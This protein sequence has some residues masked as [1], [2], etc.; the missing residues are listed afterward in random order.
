MRFSYLAI[1]YVIKA[2]V[3]CT[4]VK[5]YIH[6]TMAHT[7]LY[8][9][10]G[11]VL[12]NNVANTAYG[13]PLAR[14][15]KNISLSYYGTESYVA[16]VTETIVMIVSFA[17]SLF[18]TG[19]E[20]WLSDRNDNTQNRNNQ[21]R[22]FKAW[23][24]VL[25][26]TSVCCQLV[27]LTYL[28]QAAHIITPNVVYAAMSVVAITGSSF[29]MDMC[30]SDLTALHVSESALSLRV[31]WYLWIKCAKLVGLC[32]V[33]FSSYIFRLTEAHLIETVAP[34]AIAGLVVCVAGIVMV[35]LIDTSSNDSVEWMYVTAA[36]TDKIENLDA[37]SLNQ[38]TL[39]S[40]PPPSE[41][42]SGPS[43]QQHF[44]VRKWMSYVIVCV[45][46]ALFS[47]QRGEYKYTYYMLQRLGLSENEIRLA[48][49]LQYL[50][51]TV[52]LSATGALLKM[53]KAATVKAF[54]A[55]MTLSMA[56]RIL[57]VWADY[58]NRFDVWCAS[59]IVSTPGPV[60]ASVLQ[61]ALYTVFGHKNL[62]SGLMCG[63]SDRFLAAPV[64]YVYEYASYVISPFVVT[65]CLMMSVSVLA[66]VP[67][68]VRQWL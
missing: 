41:A 33:Q 28:N 27:L 54:I 21:R 4:S 55:S 58:G 25:P 11:I 24:L 49:G 65:L 68:T 7:T 2:N 3:L 64:V 29:M 56:A 50:L 15:F 37:L 12:C 42:V 66:L 43:T 34:A 18:V 1:S 35:T 30:V 53:F 19:I 59:V 39:L 48:N 36:G 20:W 38:C 23:L 31:S 5:F 57:Q 26:V 47:A 40:S 62:L 32:G 46:L 22:L 17:S 45:T 9:L 14:A 8:L 44:C 67:R 61:N 16:T 6:N 52:S 51:F 63:A 60:A 13:Q 10:L